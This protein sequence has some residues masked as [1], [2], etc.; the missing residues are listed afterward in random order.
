MSA[1][2]YTLRDSDGRWMAQ[3]VITDDGFFGCVSEWGNFSF[4]WR[5]FGDDFR[6]FLLGVDPGYFS[7]KMVAGLAYSINRTQKLE[8]AAERFAFRILPALQA[9]IRAEAPAPKEEA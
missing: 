4:A 3:A 9:A 5:S 7:R 6:R 2:A 8:M 1:K